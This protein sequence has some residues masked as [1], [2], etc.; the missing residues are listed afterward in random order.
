MCHCTRINAELIKM[1]M[2]S[3]WQCISVCPHP[4]YIYVTGAGLDATFCFH[5][6]GP[7][8]KHGCCGK[9]RE[10]NLSKMLFFLKLKELYFTSR[11]F[12]GCEINTPSMLRVACYAL[13]LCCILCTCRSSSMKTKTFKAIL[14]SAA[15]T[16][17]SSTP[18][19]AAATRYECRAG[20]GSCMRGPITWAI[21]TFCQRESTWTTNAGWDTMTPSGHVGS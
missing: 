4:P 15:A 18:T 11:P 1:T 21:S 5:K 9:G 13:H 3:P 10:A 6:F 2:A 14:L 8:P 19:S 16:V 7:R 20:P 17:L 12:N